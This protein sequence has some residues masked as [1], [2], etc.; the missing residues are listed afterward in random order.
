MSLMSPALAGGFFTTSTMPCLGSPDQA[1][2]E[3]TGIWSSHKCSERRSALPAIQR[4]PAP[5][6]GGLRLQEMPAPGRSAPGEVHPHLVLGNLLGP[7]LMRC[8]CFRVCVIELNHREENCS[9]SG[10]EAATPM[11]GPVDPAASPHCRLW[12][13]T[14]QAMENENRKRRFWALGF[15]NAGAT[16]WKSEHR[17]SWADD[18]LIPSEACVAWSWL[19]LRCLRGRAGEGGGLQWTLRQCFFPRKNSF[20]WS[21]GLK[22]KE[23]IVTAFS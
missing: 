11:P 14:V 21:L 3:R 18:L 10:R 15:P 13:Y 22:K 20:K 6:H 16:E 7:G 19:L 2:P 9:Q 4:C 1:R 23:K 8:G 5:S 12:K 17:R